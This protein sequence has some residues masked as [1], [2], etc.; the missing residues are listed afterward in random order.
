MVRPSELQHPDGSDQP[1]IRCRGTARMSGIDRLL[2]ACV[3]MS[4]ADNL[5]LR[6]NDEKHAIAEW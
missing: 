2:Q 5:G 3:R 6:Y 1:A 4:V